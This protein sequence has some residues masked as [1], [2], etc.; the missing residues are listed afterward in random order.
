MTI[1]DS[2]KKTLAY[3]AVFVVLGMQAAVIGPA[4]PG[5]AEQTRS[6]LSA[7][8]IL[9]VMRNLGYISGALIAGRLYDRVKG[10]PVLT[11]TILFLAINIAFIPLYS[12]L[13]ALS[14]A[15]FL[16]GLLQGVIDVG[17]NTLLVW[18]H[19]EKVSPYMNGLH[20][21]FGLGAFLAPIIIAQAIQIAGNIS[22]AFWCLAM[23]IFPCA[24]VVSRLSSP[25]PISPAKDEK[26]RP[27]LPLLVVLIALVFFFYVGT[28]ISFGGWIFTYTT[29]TGLADAASAAYL[30][31]GFWGSYTIGRLIAIPLTRRLSSKVMILCDFSILLSSLALMFLFPQSFL[32]LWIGVIGVGIGMASIF[33]TM[34][35][36]AGKNMTLTGFMTSW[37]FVGGSLG[38]MSI[39]WLI[40]QVIN[41]IDPRNIF[42]IIGGSVIADVLLFL[43][44]LVYTQKKSKS[45]VKNQP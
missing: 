16:I 3:Y 5:L 18:V 21:F 28:E 32:V 37:F 40:G 25:L 4:L 38:G 10:H 7:V 39:P 45:L 41:V 36:F 24:L 14:T 17:G 22:W 26:K 34:L 11:T 1:S 44:V 35:S 43:F 31:S 2:L 6:T 12:K 19:R 15:I 33:P 27:I 20:F 30:T 13:W 23:L 29:I 9:F 8:S 42:L